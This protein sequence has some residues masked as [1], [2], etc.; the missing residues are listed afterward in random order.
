MRQALRD[1]VVLA[2]LTFK[3]VVNHKAQQDAHTNKQLLTTESSHDSALR[4]N[5]TWLAVTNV[6]RTCFGESSATYNGTVVQSSP[7]EKPGAE[8]R[9]E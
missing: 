5:P 9:G 1:A 4:L 8:T 7:T 3:A 2:V 6:P